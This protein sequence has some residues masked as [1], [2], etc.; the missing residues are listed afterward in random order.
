MADLDLPD[1]NVLFATANPAHVHHHAAQAWLRNATRFATTP[2]TESG[3]IRLS[4]NPAIMGTSTTV[5]AALT[6]LRSLRGMPTA[7]FIVDDSSLADTA[8]DLV[9]LVGHKQVGDFHLVALAMRHR[10]RLVTF[11]SRIPGAL[12]PAGRPWVRVL[13]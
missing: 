1:V 8:L 5:Q 10:A 7:T 4:L 11:D 12:T 2:V 3:L 9:G 13:A 6:T